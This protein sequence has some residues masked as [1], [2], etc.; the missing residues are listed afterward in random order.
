MKKFDQFNTDLKKDSKATLLNYITMGF[1]KLA[2]AEN[3]NDKS[4]FLM[5]AATIMANM[6]TTTS[7]MMSRKLAQLALS[8]SKLEK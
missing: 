2:N 5:L 6:D 3:I 1:V 7:T 8:K 4:M